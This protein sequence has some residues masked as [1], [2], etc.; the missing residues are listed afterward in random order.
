MKR[1]GKRLAVASLAAAL[2]LGLVEGALRLYAR[3][4][5]PTT[6]PSYALRDDELGWRYRPGARVRQRSADFDVEIA[7]DERG[8]RDGKA[9]PPG[10][11]PIVVL[12]DSLA[13]GWGVAAEEGLAALLEEALGLPVENLGV[14]GY[15]TDQ[16]LLFFRRAKSD[17][18]P[19]TVLVIACRND[20]EEV[21]RRVSYGRPK[22][23]F[24]WAPLGST[25]PLGAVE[26][27]AREGF[28]VAHSRLARSL[29]RAY[30]EHRTPPLG[31]AEVEEARRKVVVLLRLLARECGALGARF[32]VASVGEAWLGQALG[33]VGI[34]H[35][36]LSSALERAALE[37]PVVFPRDPHWNARGHRAVAGALAPWLAEGQRDG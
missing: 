35:L 15:G 27:P 29:A 19:S 23:F 34:A 14:S 3:G 5:G 33:G 25:E 28:W 26:P 37:G 17:L 12:G 1:L 10:S 11:R 4:F 30:D 36:D 24:P 8:L 9:A 6:N 2:A 21:A 7:I 18:E 32:C 22:P 16:E 13:F 20:V 31:T